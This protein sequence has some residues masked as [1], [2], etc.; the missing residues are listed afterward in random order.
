MRERKPTKGID[1]KAVRVNLF[2]KWVHSF[3]L[4][5]IIYYMVSKNQSNLILNKNLIVMALGNYLL[6]N[7]RYEKQI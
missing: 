5:L 1:K 7:Q 3:E 2:Y 4:F 6:D